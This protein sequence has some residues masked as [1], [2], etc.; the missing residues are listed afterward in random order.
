MVEQFDGFE[1][2]DE[3]QND[4]DTKAVL[5]AVDAVIAKRSPQES[6]DWICDLENKLSDRAEALAANP[7]VEG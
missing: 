6:Y 1:D 3:F 7:E 2:E 4:S 5:A